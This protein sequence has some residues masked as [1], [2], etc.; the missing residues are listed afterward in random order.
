MCASRAVCCSA[1]ASGRGSESCADIVAD[2]ATD[3]RAA[4]KTSWTLCSAR[5]RAREER[6]PPP[7]RLAAESPTRSARSRPPPA[8]S[9]LSTIKRPL[10]ALPWRAHT[11]SP[12]ILPLRRQMRTPRG[13][14]PARYAAAF[15]QARTGG[16]SGGSVGDGTGKAGKGKDKDGLKGAR[17]PSPR[18]VRLLSPALPPRAPTLTQC[19]A[20]RRTPQR[21]RDRARAG[22]EGP[23]RRVRP[24]PSPPPRQVPHLLRLG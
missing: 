8:L 19:L 14:V 23:R 20:A 2:W 6:R 11:L 15:A 21:V 3:W 10:A 1:R 13:Q 16:G 5:T 4:L 18:D 12:T 9:M 7:P 24:S 22:Q 17:N